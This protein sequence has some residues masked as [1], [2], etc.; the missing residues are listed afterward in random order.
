MDQKVG[1]RSLCYAEAPF[2]ICSAS[3]V[4]SKEGEGPLKNL[5]DKVGTDD[6][7]GQDTWEEAESQLQKEAMSLL[8]YK[9]RRKP[10]DIRYLFAGDL[11]GQTIASS[12]GLKEFQVPLFGLYGACSTCGESLALASMTVAAGY[13]NEVVAIT[14]SHFASA[15]KQFRFPLEYAKDRKSVV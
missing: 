14:S 7:F 13:A 6:F 12:F 10:E 5:F 8:L 2:L 15:E 9:S 1:L 11:L 3:V 4:G